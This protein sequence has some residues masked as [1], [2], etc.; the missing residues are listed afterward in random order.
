[1]EGKATEMGGVER[2][3]RLGNR[4]RRAKEGEG[5][6]LSPLLPTFTPINVH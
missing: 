6:V 2:G 5:M 3:R 1:M 4:E